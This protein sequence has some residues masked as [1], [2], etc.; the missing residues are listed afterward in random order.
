MTSSDLGESAIAEELGTLRAATPHGDDS[1]EGDAPP[2]V[3]DE[4]AFLD[5]VV[6]HID[7]DHTGIAQ[8][9]DKVSQW[10][11]ETDGVVDRPRSTTDGSDVPDITL[12]TPK[13]TGS[14]TPGSG[15]AAP[16]SSPT[17]SA[18]GGVGVADAH[19]V[20]APTP[21]SEDHTGEKSPAA[22]DGSC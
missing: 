18:S 11:D 14:T 15:S 9:R 16:S 7:E 20:A 2:H 12:S 22:G 13:S 19:G 8:L 10:Y 21:Q 17:S 4:E 5:A 1:G 3:R 6:S